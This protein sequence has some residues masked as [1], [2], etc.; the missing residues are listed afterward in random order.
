MNLPTTMLAAR[1][2]RVGAAAELQIDTVPVPQPGPGQVLIR[3]ESASVNFSDVKRRRGDA[4]PFPTALPYTPGSEVAGTVAALGAGVTAPAIG[5]PVFALVGGDGQGGCA[6]FALAYAPQ[7]NAL[8]PGFDADRACGLIVAGATAMIL[9]RHVVPL[10]PGQSILVPAAAGAVGSYVVQ[11][12]RHFGAGLVIGAVSTPAKAAA[13]RAAGAHVTVDSNRADWADELRRA[14]DGRGVDVLL[15][16]AGG[17]SLA[18]ALGALAPFGR[19][20]VYGAASGANAALDAGTLGRFFYAPAPNQTLAAFNVGGWFI[21]RPSLA[22]AALGEL[23]GLVAAGAIRTP[24]VT[25][26][27]LRDAALAHRLLETRQTLGKL[28]LKPW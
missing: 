9:L 21:E 11:L 6:Q 28:V 23:I 24:A 17:D 1:S 14:T 19:A 15:E 20:V 4:Y 2:H 8:P 18:Q 7:V 10:S 22:G 26:M 5:T 25:S 3:V 16:S 27:P 13:A 12:A